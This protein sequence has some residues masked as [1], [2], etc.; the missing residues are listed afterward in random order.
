[1][2]TP[3]SVTNLE[4]FRTWRDDDD[5]S[6]D[7]LLRRIRGLEPPTENM[8]A[9]R[10]FHEALENAAA[11]EIETLRAGP[12][13]FDFNCAAEIHMANLREIPVSREYGNLLVRGR[14]DCWIGQEITDFK[15]TEQF[16]ADRLLEGFQWR[17]YLDMTGCNAFCWN[18]FVIK[19]SEAQ[20]YEVRQCHTLRQKRYPGLHEDCERLA[21]D[22][23][24]VLGETLRT[25]IPEA[26]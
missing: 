17:Y 6:L 7:W 21:L 24:A 13:R 22:Y 9:G 3:A 12:Y 15:T 2:L 23:H 8:L 19:E 18:V 1:M 16:D 20:C 14:V 10:A 11:P 25:L 4:L 5:L 26:A